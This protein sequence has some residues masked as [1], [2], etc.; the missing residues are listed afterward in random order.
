MNFVSDRKSYHTH[1]KTH[2]P[3]SIT[4]YTVSKEKCKKITKILMKLVGLTGEQTNA[5][6][7]LI[8]QVNVIFIN[9]RPIQITF[10]SK[11]MS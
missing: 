7:I 11:I 5:K 10:Q 3:L 4:Y 1:Y 2:N 9:I 8:F 6:K